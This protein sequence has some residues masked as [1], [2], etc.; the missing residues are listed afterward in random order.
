[1]PLWWCVLWDLFRC[2]YFMAPE[3][4]LFFFFVV[5]V[6]CVVHNFSLLMLDVLSLLIS[7]KKFHPHFFF[8]ASLVG[9]VACL[10][11]AYLVLF[12]RD[13]R[14]QESGAEKKRHT[15]IFYIK[16]KIYYLRCPLCTIPSIAGIFGR[17]C[18]CRNICGPTTTSS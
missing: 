11:L 7:E 8:F 16:Y 15:E 14:V 9:F 1:M 4:C 18:V 17:T 2:R 13:E 10:V 12:I 3:I 5:G 6:H